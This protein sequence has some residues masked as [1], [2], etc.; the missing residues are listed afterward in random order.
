MQPLHYVPLILLALVLVSIIVVVV[1]RKDR[2]VNGLTLAGVLLGL[3]LGWTT[4]PEGLFGTKSDFSDLINNSQVAQEV[5]KNALPY[6][7]ISALV[8]WIVGFVLNGQGKKAP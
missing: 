3:L 2:I 6:V 5:W 8:G 1:D 7:V 4:R